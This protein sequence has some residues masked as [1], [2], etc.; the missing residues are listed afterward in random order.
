V[1]H[2]ATYEQREC[3]YRPRTHR[4][5]PGL[6][7]KVCVEFE[8]EHSGLVITAFLAQNIRVAEVQRWP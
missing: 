5:F 7:L 3:F 6:F 2:D 4:R 8:S 1:M